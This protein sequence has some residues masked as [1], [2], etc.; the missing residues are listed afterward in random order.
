MAVSVRLHC[1]NDREPPSYHFGAVAYA[2]NLNIECESDASTDD[3]LAIDEA[4][5]EA[6]FQKL[7][8]DSS[9]WNFHLYAIRNGQQGLSAFHLEQIAV[10]AIQGPGQ[11]SNL[12]DWLAAGAPAKAAQYWTQPTTLGSAKDAPIVVR[13]TDLG[14][15]HRLRASHIWDA[16]IPH[17][18]SLTRLAELRAEPVPAAGDQALVIVPFPTDFKPANS[19]A[20]I[21]TPGTG[22]W[23][24]TI[25]TDAGDTLFCRVNPLGKPPS[26]WPDFLDEN[27][28][29]TINESAQAVQ[30][31][32]HWMALGWGG[33][34]SGFAVL[35]GLFQ[36]DKRLST[37]I[38]ERLSPTWTRTAVDPLKAE[39]H[40]T[41][42]RL[43]LLTG[44]RAGLDPLLIGLLRPASGPD[45]AGELLLPLVNKLLYAAQR[46]PL[47]LNSKLDKR[48]IVAALRKLLAT[49]PCIAGS[50]GA[51]DTA[52][53][54]LEVY[55]LNK[56]SDTDAS[57]ARTVFDAL[58]SGEEALSDLDESRIR[59]LAASI[60]PT[61]MGLRA[62]PYSIVLQ[63]VQRMEQED[64]VE[65]ALN[66]LFQGAAKIAGK[67]PA[68]A[69]ASELADSA[70]PAEDL[71]AF[72]RDVSEAWQAYV[73]LLATNFN[74][75][76]AARHS[77]CADFI[78]ELRQHVRNSWPPTGGLL[79]K[80]IENA[81]YYMRRRNAYHRG[82]TPARCFDALLN[83][84][85]PCDL[86]YLDGLHEA[87]DG[88]LTTAYRQATD[89]IRQLLNPKLGFVPDAAPM[90]LPIVIAGMKDSE[91]LEDFAKEFNGIGIALRR[92][93]PGQ[94]DPQ[95]AH[96]NLASIGWNKGAHETVGLRTWLPA[97][98]DG[99]I[100]DAIL[101]HGYPLICPPAMDGSA[102]GPS[103][104]AQPFVRASVVD[105]SVHTGFSPVYKLAYGR[106]YEAFAF[107]TTNSGSL[108][109]ALRSNELDDPWHLGEEII[110]PTNVNRYDYQRRTAV[111][112]IHLVESPGSGSTMAIGNVPTDVHPLSRDY[113][114]LSLASS[115]DRTS[116]LDLFSSTNGQGTLPLTDSSSMQ[117]GEVVLALRE[118]KWSGD[119]ATLDVSFIQRA[120]SRIV[121]ITL[122]NL[123]QTTQDSP[124]WVTVSCEAI[125]KCVFTY[126]VRT[127]L[128]TLSAQLKPRIE[129]V[130]HFPWH[131]RLTLRSSGQTVIT[132]GDPRP[133]ATRADT[134]LLI[135][136]PEQEQTQWMPMV[137]SGM[138]A[139][140]VM[141]RVGLFD[142]ERWF[143]NEELSGS[144]PEATQAILMDQLLYG[145]QHRGAP[146]RKTIDQETDTI[147]KRLDH[148]PDPSVDT[149]WAELVCLDTLKERL[150]NP[151]PIPIRVGKAI[152][153]AVA[154]LSSGPSDIEPVRDILTR[155]DKA[156]RCKIS[157]GSQPDK[158]ELLWIPGTL[159]I[160]VPPG[161]IAQLR[162]IPAVPRANFNAPSAA[163]PAA[164]HQGYQQLT[165]GHDDKDNL[166]FPGYTLQIETMLYVAEHPF[167]D[168]APRYITT[169]SAPLL[170]QYELTAAQSIDSSSRDAW[171]LIGKIDVTTQQ[172]R[173]HGL[174]MTHTIDPTL[175]KVRSD[176]PPPI[177]PL[178]A[179]STVLEFENEIFLGRSEENAQT[180][181]AVLLH[182]L[183]PHDGLTKES[184]AQ[185]G[186]ILASF[187]WQNSS[188]TY[189][190]HRFRAYSRYAGALTQKARSNWRSW[191][192]N[193]SKAAVWMVRVALLA[194][195]RIARLT[196]PQ[197]RALLPL[198]Q[199]SDTSITPAVMAFLQEPPCSEVGLAERVS[200][201]I[202]T[203]I[204]Y[205]FPP[206]ASGTN[207]T[208][209]TEVE[210]L[211]Y[212]KEIGPDPRLT[213]SRMNEALARAT[214]LRLEGPI[215]QTFDSSDAVDPRF[216][217]SV[218]TLSPHFANSDNTPALEEHFFA[219]VMRRYAD[220]NWTVQ[221]LSDD[222][223]VHQSQWITF[224]SAALVDGELVRCRSV[225]DGHAETLLSVRGLGTDSA[226]IQIVAETALLTSDARA[227]NEPYVLATINPT[228]LTA[229]AVLHTATGAKQFCATLFATLAPDNKNKAPPSAF[230]I[231]LAS[232]H[233]TTQ[234]LGNPDRTGDLHLVAPNGRKAT[235]IASTPTSLAWVRTNRNFSHL[236]AL[237]DID[238][239]TSKQLDSRRCYAK[240]NKMHLS[241]FYRDDAGAHIRIS[242]C[243]SQTHNRFPLQMH[244]HL[245]LLH[246][247]V[248]PGKGAP[249][250]VFADA[251]FG[252][253]I[254]REVQCSEAAARSRY[255][256]VVE[257]EMPA[258]ILCAIPPAQGGTPAARSAL[259]PIYQRAYFDLH[260]TGGETSKIWKLYVRFLGSPAHVAT[261]R[262][263]ELKLQMP[264]AVEP[265]PNGQP[266]N[267][268]TDDAVSLPLSLEKGQIVEVT[269]RRDFD[270]AL[271][272]V[273]T[274][275][276]ERDGTRTLLGEKSTTF[277]RA[278]SPTGILIS[279]AAKGM[280]ELWADCSLLHFAHKDPDDDARTPQWLADLL[281]APAG[282]DT[283]PNALAPRSL[284]ALQEA[285]ARLVAVSPTLEMR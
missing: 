115:T 239:D 116:S 75:A 259:P 188:A 35:L 187:A 176:A 74:G 44:L 147:G 230:P 252:G 158:L 56:P 182:P 89:P 69:I 231:A 112:A 196:R 146:F 149:I 166:L 175:Y 60:S 222:L 134:P 5:A 20:V 217:N 228:H 97:I 165:V 207:R 143:S 10:R 65:Q 113:P 107:A 283:L 229:L 213:Y 46:L 88:F 174:P 30:R 257:I 275:L 251:Y 78:V 136:R 102:S 209:P 104:K 33:I 103:E 226:Q 93:D 204:G 29:L 137:P 70:W 55:G 43:H 235:T 253:Q 154:G 111:G 135:L 13:Q 163:A 249:V 273:S 278:T 197:L 225:E 125:N 142:F 167:V 233:W 216:A 285:Q 120:T 246:S 164:F 150:N 118:L 155:L 52:L 50:I 181:K 117:A 184:E 16:P 76:D 14:A 57:A 202:Q 67:T 4:T 240:L 208:A 59:Q 254:L 11:V 77:M 151:P 98:Q 2:L 133:D 92:L 159:S 139:E 281:F 221:G 245:V 266:Q 27:G 161:V 22:Q 17:K 199:A 36:N 26:L 279:V 277:P 25:E 224:N 272:C 141:P 145:Y 219:V 122:N 244:R 32:F 270:A 190:R 24:V 82:N 171:R 39:L 264:D 206:D 105:F 156:F 90:P 23:D 170:R 126:S 215:G 162:L 62:S 255:V 83:G 189:F 194:D 63:S 121:T 41:N 241:F 195:A 267:I 276:V 232:V 263:V 148:L 91:A 180:E 173:H 101:Y 38:H 129:A 73:D 258:V 71:D 260:A 214:V 193:H 236:W 234:P 64:G 86:G 31:I 179:D 157:I 140:I 3:V 205:G 256:R 152:A 250:E 227:G 220:P 183:L 242:L 114:R 42:L 100:Q 218:F 94:A 79:R 109:T 138:E 34:V 274:V 191:D 144:I 269:L 85:P 68:D 95:W 284:Q 185:N 66:A 237:L 261:F 248:A 18:F 131:I 262:D 223:T 200:A 212:R 53:S 47:R 21:E 169:R 280:G 19:L 61:I 28:Y 8:L 123:Q 178:H 48:T 128:E 238:L 243:G 49:N 247:T 211:D 153:E 110:A 9:S 203:G 72:R 51:E 130:Q 172:W 40:A 54:L 80:C 168:L 1:V 6:I 12:T 177:W 45:V 282:D 108:P 37:N 81:D 15:S 96:L 201:E 210:I 7:L 198:T 58:V 127:A 268:A 186:T 132:F 160:N 87:V 192:E 119:A 99:Q 124:G 265:V 84:L 271:G 106:A